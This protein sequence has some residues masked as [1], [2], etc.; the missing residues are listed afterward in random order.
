M[1]KLITLIAAVGLFTQNSHAV[2]HSVGLDKSLYTSD[3][4]IGKVAVAII[5][6][7]SNGSFDPSTENWSEDRKSLAVSKIM[8][9]LNWWTK[10]NTR[11]PLSFTYVTETVTTKYE[12]VTRPYYDESLWIPEVMG[13]LGFSGTRFTATR[14][15]VNDMRSKYKTDWG[16]VIFMCDSLN[17]IDG[18]FSNGLFA[19]SYLGG[20]FMVMTYTN[21]GYGIGNMDVVVAHEAGHIFNALDQY[22][23]A[24][25]PSDYTNGYFPT[26]NGNHAYSTIANEPNS[27]MRGG[28]RWGLDEW[29][30]QAVGWRDNNKNGQD[31]ILDQSPNVSIKTQTTSSS[32]SNVYTGEAKVTVLARQGNASGN[33]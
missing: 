32:G 1:K 16:F 31:D 19:Y 10:Q 21:D 2:L 26:I 29:T 30:K 22:A 18:K 27:I 7:E 28:I 25:S 20:P 14:N 17:D 13:K 3:F 33:G 4:M 11:S 23:G 5:F 9:G 15:Y 8:S 12:P 24:S 6:V